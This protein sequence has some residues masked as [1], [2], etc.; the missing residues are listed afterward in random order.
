MRRTWRIY[1]TFVSSSLV[2]ELEYRANFVAKLFGNAMWLGFFV[3]ILLVIYGKSSQVAGWSR[4]DSMLLAGSVFL[5][6]AVSGIFFFSLQ[7]I[8]ELVRQGTMDFVLT[9]PIDTQFWVSTRRFNFDQIG[10]LFVGFGMVYWGVTES[11]LTPSP[12]QW[13]AF[14]GGLASAL[15]LFYSFNLALM[16]T[17]MWFVRVDNLWVLSDSVSNVIKYP[18]DIYPGALRRV[19]TFYVPMAFLATVPTSQLARGIDLS[20]LGIGA[21]WAVVAFVASRTF[22]RYATRHYASASS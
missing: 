17:A 6:T 19:L 4:G 5:M 15:V 14:L 10:T 21:I 1:R 18:I 3:M 22:W 7:E 2:R 11:H 16:T 20:M 13:V 8:P 12:V 9:K